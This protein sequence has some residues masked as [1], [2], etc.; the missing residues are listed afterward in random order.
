[1]KD[2]NKF[3]IFEDISSVFLV[4]MLSVF[5]FWFDGKGYTNIVNA[6]ADA[7]HIVC[8]GYIA[9][10]ALLILE[11]F[12]VGNIKPAEIAEKFKSVSLVQKLVIAYMLITLFSGLLSEYGMQTWKGISRNE[13]ALTICVY[14][15]CFLFVSMFGKPKKW[16]LY[17]LGASTLLFSILCFVQLTG[18]N[19]FHLYPEGMN[20]FGAYKDYSGAYIG[21]IG[22]VDLVAAY[23]CVVIPL[24]WVPVL[25]LKEKQR[26]LLL[27]PLAAAL[28]VLFGISVLAGFVG[29]F[30]GA[31]LALPVVLPLSPRTRKVMAIV[32]AALIIMGIAF[33]FL[34]DVGGGLLHEAH[35]LLHGNVSDSFGTGRVY[36]WR[37][38]IQR[39]PEQLFFGHGPDTM[40]KSD[41]EPFSRYDAE[42]DRTLTAYV[43]VAHSEYLNVLYHQG[44]FALIAYLAALVIA[45]VKWIKNSGNDAAA[46][47]GTAVLCYCIQALFGIS[48]LLSAPFFWICLGLLD[49]S[50]KNADAL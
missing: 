37:N 12:A 29:V 32:I 5:L 20:Y 50:M 34:A 22:N 25:R 23:L 31:V 46:I 27:V 1:M 13:G 41:I 19:P 49:G 7:F 9:L 18:T 36:I 21:T 39:V 47:F 26:F 44:I 11:S 33:L 17:P 4:L 45:A 24:M 8:G 6:K 42:N 28:G 40:S 2:K 48:M 38:V 16:M 30:C 3:K 43:D 15:L 14:C 10:V 35:E